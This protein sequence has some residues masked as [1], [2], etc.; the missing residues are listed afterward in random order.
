[1]V[2]R[3]AIAL[4]VSLA[5]LQATATAFACTI[6]CTRVSSTKHVDGDAQPMAMH[7]HSHQGHSSASECCPHTPQVSRSSCSSRP[8]LSAV[9]ASSRVNPNSLNAPES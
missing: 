2:V 3:R 5:L 9:E 7:H 8:Q 1:M 6:N 4:V